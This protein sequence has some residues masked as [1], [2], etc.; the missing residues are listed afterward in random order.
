MVRTVTVL[1]YL[2][3][4]R[5]IPFCRNEVPF[6]GCNNSI[7]HFKVV[8][9]IRLPFNLFIGLLFLS[10]SDSLTQAPFHGYILYIRWE[11]VTRV[12]LVAFISRH[13]GPYWHC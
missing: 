10:V 3:K 7:G 4:L 8:L 2:H 13:K 6:K 11:C 12:N 1:R 9:S 5:S